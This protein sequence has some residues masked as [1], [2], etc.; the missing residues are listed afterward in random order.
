MVWILVVEGG[1]GDSRSAGV[2]ISA[3]SLW[4]PLSKSLVTSYKVRYANVVNLSAL[5]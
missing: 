2:A 3:T 5:T 4:W 1:M